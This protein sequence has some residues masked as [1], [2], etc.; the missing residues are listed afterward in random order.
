[1]LPDT[2]RDALAR[3]QP[4]KAASLDSYR[5]SALYQTSSK[6][7]TDTSQNFNSMIAMLAGVVAPL[8]HR[9]ERRPPYADT[10]L[11]V[12]GESFVLI[13]LIAMHY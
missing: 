12:Q 6:D 9:D 11:H 1:M 8:F 3:I 2:A 7:T 4:V 10:R 5:P 13:E